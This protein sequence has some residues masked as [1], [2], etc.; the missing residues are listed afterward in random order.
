MDR[1]RNKRCFLENPN[2]PC[3]GRMELV[4]LEYAQ[5]T[6]SRRYYVCEAHREGNYHKSRRRKSRLSQGADSHSTSTETAGRN[7]E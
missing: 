4:Y 5:Q 7:N 2:E 1:R 6:G 3:W